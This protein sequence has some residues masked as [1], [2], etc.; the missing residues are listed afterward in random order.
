MVPFLKQTARYAVEH[1]GDDLGSLCIVL[2]NRR[3][4]LFL[5]KYLAEEAGRVTWAPEI[6]SV[7]DFISEISG[8]QEVDN[9]DLL[10]EL[11]GVH[12]EI[13]EKKAQSFEEF[14]RWGPQILADFNEIDRYMADAREL[15]ATLTEA[16]AISLWNLDNQPLTDFEAKYLAFYQSLFEYYTRLTGRLLAKQQAYQGL[17]FRYAADR[18]EASLKKLP[19]RHILLVLFMITVKMVLN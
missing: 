17:S 10:F 14:L 15:F 8:L 3:G 4:G 18:I 1:F 12:C 11:F 16:R 2:P 7:E 13:E 5:R 19:W 9:L 6:F